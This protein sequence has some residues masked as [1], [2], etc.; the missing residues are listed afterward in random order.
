MC[1]ASQLHI[2]YLISAILWSRHYFYSHFTDEN[3]EAL[4]GTLTCPRSHSW[5]SWDSDAGSVVFW[6]ETSNHPAVVCPGFLKGTLS[7]GPWEA[8]VG[9][10]VEKARGHWRAGG[11]Q[12]T[13]V[14][15]WWSG[16]CFLQAVGSGYILEDRRHEPEEGRRFPAERTRAKAC[17]HLSFSRAASSSLSLEIDRGPVCMCGL[18]YVLMRRGS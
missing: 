4:K 17:R 8:F 9:F 16:G 3:V 11:E 2:Y 1:Q 6:L 14:G 10:K 12:T 15:S 7:C 13:W 18:M 5:Q